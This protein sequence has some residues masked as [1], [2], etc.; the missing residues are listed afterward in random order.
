[1]PTGNEQ[2]SIADGASRWR[3]LQRLDAEAARIIALVADDWGIAPNQLL[4]ASRCVAQVA[5][6]RQVAM[7][8]LHTQCS[9]SQSDVASAFWR[10]RT[11]VRHA[12]SV[13][14]DGRDVADFEH[15][16]ARLE[17]VIAGQPFEEDLRDA[18]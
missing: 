12:C 3:R 14:E 6:A 1:M 2:G 9:R 8:L 18:G 16:I 7:Y 11:T 4:H 5:L 10:D 15:R 17:G 13:I